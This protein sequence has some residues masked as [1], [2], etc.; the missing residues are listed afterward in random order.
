MR[1]R[2]LANWALGGLLAVM[3][4]DTAL[5]QARLTQTIELQ[6]G[7][8]AIYVEVQPEDQDI[9]SVFSGI[10]V[11]SVWRWF[12]E[13]PG[14]DFIQDP[15]EGLLEINGWFG[16]FPEPRPEAFLSTL[17]TVT[18]N[19]A[20]LVDL[21]SQS[22]VTLSITGTPVVRSRSWLSSGFTLTGFPVTSTNPPTFSEFFAPSPAHAGQPVYALGEDG[23]WDLIPASTAIEEGRAYWVFTS[24]ASNYQ[25][26][27][28]VSLE[29]QVE[30]DYGAALNEAQI[31]LFNNT[32]LPTDF[33]VRR[34]S[35]ER[36]PLV[37]ELVDPETQ[38]IG[39]PLLPEVLAVAV[40]P[41]GDSLLNLGIQRRDFTETHQ[42]EILEIDN[43]MGVRQRIFV[44]GD[45]IQPV[46]LATAKNGAR[47]P[48]AVMDPFAG[49]WIGTVLVNQVSESQLAGTTPLPTNHP[50]PMRVM[51]HVDQAGEVKF[52]K[53]V[54]KMWQ[55]GVYAPSPV[56]PEF[57]VVDE[58]G[59][60]V[61]LTRDEL[62]PNF[63]G[64]AVREGQPVG[65]RYSTVTYDFPGDT[66]DMTGSVGPNG[67]VSVVIE[68]PFDHP[69]N[70][71]F[72]R[73][74]PDH[75]NLDP[76]FLNEVAE[77]QDLSREVTLTFAAEDPS[78]SNDPAYLSEFIAGT[79]QET[80]LGLHRNP[81]F[82]AGTFRLERISTVSVLNQ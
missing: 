42:E 23:V 36:V 61:L 58:P 14:V 1:L 28:Q 77:A 37:F 67:Q 47:G 35:S 31:A 3:L 52:L 22:P 21:D 54:I 29:S 69:T 55:D 10:P 30:L 40:P 60:F 50:F 24:G 59:R 13:T 49:L 80:I 9:E 48:K 6:P 45:T 27:L 72:H 44:A 12:P 66:L 20:Y 33:F 81:I 53:E 82:V 68:V 79:F 38:E 65:I 8:N 39:F 46:I 57:Q 76:Q 41:D 63:S 62:I 11:A 18:A 78:G 15:A 70:P 43:G 7:W 4:A 75:D 64:A 32:D 73:Y 71:F 25:G 16:Y 2:S 17:F 5:A 56:N 74:H 26:P 19:Q 34:I 51:L